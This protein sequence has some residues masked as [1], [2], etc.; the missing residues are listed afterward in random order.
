LAINNIFI[1]LAENIKD[2]YERD[3]STKQFPLEVVL[4]S[5]LY[6]FL[7]EQVDLNNA[8]KIREFA[9][10]FRDMIKRFAVKY[11][12]DGGKSFTNA[13]LGEINED[14]YSTDCEYLKVILIVTAFCTKECLTSESNPDDP[15]N[16][17]D[18]ENH[19][20]KYQTNKIIRNILQCMVNEE[21]TDESVS[22]IM[23]KH[24]AR[25]DVHIRA[26]TVGKGNTFGGFVKELKKD[27]DLSSFC[28]QY[29]KELELTE[30]IYIGNEKKMTSCTPILIDMLLGIMNIALYAAYLKANKKKLNIF[31][32]SGRSNIIF[33]SG[34][35]GTNDLGVIKA[36]D[37]NV[38]LGLHP[39]AVET[40]LTNSGRY[41]RPPQH[42]INLDD[43]VSRVL[44]PLNGVRIRIKGDEQDSAF[45]WGPSDFFQRLYYLRVTNKVQEAEEDGE[46]DGKEDRDYDYDISYAELAEALEKLVEAE[47]EYEGAVEEW[48]DMKKNLDVTK[49]VTSSLQM[50]SRKLSHAEEAKQQQAIKKKGA[51]E[52][53]DRENKKQKKRAENA[54]NALD[55]IGF[56]NFG[57]P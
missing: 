56:D 54:A 17:I 37:A 33:E 50:T 42:M 36:E 48:K 41:R 5:C 38:A 7:Q 9:F 57:C 10:F 1:K 25:A 51:R 22:E 19:T 29:Q 28:N 3:K 12:D 11:Y 46:E 30:G 31:L 44:E 20:I 34:N 55:E 40:N 23:N 14:L 6:D 18:N 32:A 27:T 21:L 35:D 26:G 24:I 39:N 4:I 16:H 13:N 2:V 53:E 47:K 45:V 8:D 15:I 52:K 49:R 43:G